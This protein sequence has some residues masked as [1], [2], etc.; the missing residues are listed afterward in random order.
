MLEEAHE[1]QQAEQERLTDFFEHAGIKAGL[2]P[3]FM[4]L[5]RS[6]AGKDVVCGNQSPV[7]WL[8]LY[9]RPRKGAAYQPA[10]VGV[11]GPLALARWPAD[12]TI[13]VPTGPGCCVSRKPPRAR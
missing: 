5:V 8:L 2:W 1:E 6:A 11:P 13:L 4:Q 10:G 12:L 7:Q 9:S 3:V